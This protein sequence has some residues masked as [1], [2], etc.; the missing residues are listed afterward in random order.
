M[1]VCVCVCVCVRSISLHILII[2]ISF[3]P[4]CTFHLICSLELG[5]PNRSLPGCVTQTAPI[6][7]NYVFLRTPFMFFE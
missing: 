3:T 5:S 6:F 2:N 1:C 7:V 4:K